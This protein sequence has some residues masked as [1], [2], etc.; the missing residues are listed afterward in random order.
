MIDYISEI[1]LIC[2]QLAIEGFPSESERL[3]E[4]LSS[5]FTG[6][7]VVMAIKWTLQEILKEDTNIVPDIRG[8]MIS[9]VDEL[10]SFLGTS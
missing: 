2:S 8:R 3:A 5:S 10:A 1:K 7:E 4:A 9:L 6:T